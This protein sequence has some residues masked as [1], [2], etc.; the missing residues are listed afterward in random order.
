M[1]V[2]AFISPQ[3][4]DSE[5]ILTTL[6]E[7]IPA[8]HL[9]TFHTTKLLAQRLQDPHEQE[10]AALLL[11]PTCE[12]LKELVEIREQFRGLPVILVLPDQTEDTVAQSHALWPR[13]VGYGANFIAEIP[14]IISRM[15][16]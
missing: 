3:A 14:T 2:L 7:A 11:A 16:K 5:Q 4:T 10:D 15:L 12:E 1:S 6:A 13:V 9:D 8:R